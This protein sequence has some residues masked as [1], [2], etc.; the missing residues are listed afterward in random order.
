M[1]Y[2][3]KSEPQLNVPFAK[4]KQHEILFGKV[5]DENRGSN[6][7]KLLNPPEIHNDPY[8][9]LRD[10]NKDKNSEILDYIKQ[11]NEYVDNYMQDT[12]ELQS[13][14]LN[15]ILEK[16][17]DSK[18]SYPTKHTSKLYLWKAYENRD[19]KYPIYYASN[20]F[21]EDR[22]LDNP[23]YNNIS[24]NVVLDV[25]KLAEQYEY[26]DIGVVSFNKDSSVMC[27]T[28]DTTGDELYDV[29][30]VDQYTNERLDCCLSGVL[31]SNIG[32]VGN[33]YIYYTRHDDANRI[34]QVWCYDLQTNRS[35]QVYKNDNELFEVDFG[36]SN[37]E[38][39]LFIVNG[40]SDSNETY[41]IDLTHQLPQLQLIRPAQDNV[42]YDVEHHGDFF[43][44]L[45]NENDCTNF[46]LMRTRYYSDD[47]VGRTFESEVWVDV[48][49]YDSAKYL[50]S[51]QPYAEFM[52]MTYRYNGRKQMCVLNYNSLETR[53]FSFEDQN[54]SFGMLYEHGFDKDSILLTYNSPI[55]PPT[56]YRYDMS[57][58]ERKIVKRATIFG[59]DNTNYEMDYIN[60]TVRDGESVPVTIVRNRTTHTKNMLLYGYGAYGLGMDA[61]FSASRLSLLD[62]GIVFAIAHV[63]GGNEKGYSWYLNG[64]MF[65]KMNTFNDFI[66]ITE[67]F[68]ADNYNI[69]AMGGSAGGLLMGAVM[70]MRPELYQGIVAQV[71]FV[72]ALNSMMDSSIPLTVPEWLEWGNPN[73]ADSYEYMKQYSPYDNLQPV[74]YP[75][76]LITAG[77][78]DPRVQYW[79]P[80]KFMAKL[81]EMNDEMNRYPLR[82]RFKNESQPV[83]LMKMR[84]NEGHVTSSDVVKTIKDSVYEYAFILKI[85]T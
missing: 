40:S 79:E 74:N 14:M 65:N 66:D 69:I 71:P 77:I 36:V 32:W 45:T 31:Y 52:V 73:E 16:T 7:D 12:T 49:P 80:T 48:F 43:Y 72:D 18:D 24:E 38:E 10:T 61:T 83:H 70:T 33:R 15:E 37:D 28:I 2:E 62:R 44:I 42:K 9:W 55:S 76:L 21:D 17:V 59:F 53:N 82:N 35:V 11:E 5:E 51:I 78:N 67:V 41:F 19:S 34:N 85:F 75:N 56:V 22:H 68:R 25:G 47:W 4:K 57:T 54:Y 50:T 6:D 23:K 3:T 20:E 39:F 8:Y 27:Y 63:R 30:F 26:C 46:K 29:Y 81:R 1:A 58:L 64:K 84:L 60:I 13:E